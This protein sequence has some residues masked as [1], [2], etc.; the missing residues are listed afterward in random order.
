MRKNFL[1]LFLMALLPLAGWA[2]APTISLSKTQYTYIGGSMETAVRAKLTITGTYDDV[3]FYAAGGTSD[4][5]VAPE[6]TAAGVIPVNVGGY[7]V[8]AAYAGDW[9]APVYFRIMPKDL[10]LTATQVEVGYGNYSVIAGGAD[11]PSGY[12]TV[13][14][15]V[16]SDD[17]YDVNI[18]GV[19]GSSAAADAANGAAGSYPYNLSIANASSGNPNY[20]LKVIG[21]GSTLTINKA[22]LTI[23]TENKAKIYGNVDPEFTAT[24]VG[25]VPGEDASV[26]TDLEITRVGCW[27]LC[28]QRYR[29]IQQL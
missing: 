23:T 11:I 10:E 16:G 14:G 26:L 18:T 20:S 12:Y 5:P 17:I 21:T 25:F 13:S 4:E 3:K 2:D 9:S 27:Y 8:R 7:Y 1:L 24:Y 19:K 28:Y 22:P 29:N 6:A 15:F